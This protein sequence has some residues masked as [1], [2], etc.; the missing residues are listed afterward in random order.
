M[1]MKIG[2]AHNC[3]PALSSESAHLLGVGPVV[4]AAGLA[5]AGT[6]QGPQGAW[7][8]GHLPGGQ[9]VRL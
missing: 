5:W 3:S 4:G 2:P 9:R 7:G 8:T 6:P 1:A